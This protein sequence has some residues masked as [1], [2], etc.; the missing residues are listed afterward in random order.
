[1][2][3]V[4]PNFKRKKDFRAA[5]VAGAKLRTFN[6]S[7]MFPTTQDGVDVIEGPHYPAQHM[8]YAQVEV[9]NGVVV[10]VIK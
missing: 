4:N 10:R 5:V 3:Y 7:G 2:A 1:M 6:P 9:R 8:W